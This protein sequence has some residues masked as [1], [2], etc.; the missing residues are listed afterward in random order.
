MGSKKRILVALTI[1][2]LVFLIGVA[3]FKILGGPE[4]SVIDSL[5]PDSF[6]NILS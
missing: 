2:I 5:R 4:W 3:G 6:G 1:V